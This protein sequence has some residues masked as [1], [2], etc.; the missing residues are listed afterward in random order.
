[1]NKNKARIILDTYTLKVFQHG[2]PT[3]T[4]KDINPNTWAEMKAILA[5]FFQTLIEED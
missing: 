1:M 2:D 3:L 4:K 5:Q